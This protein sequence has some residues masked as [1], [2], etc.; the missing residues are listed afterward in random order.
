MKVKEHRS[1]YYREST[2]RSLLSFC[3]SKLYLD[4]QLPHWARNTVIFDIHLNE[5]PFSGIGPEEGNLCKP[6]SSC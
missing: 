4:N 3:M 2:N 5:E 6:V 1:P